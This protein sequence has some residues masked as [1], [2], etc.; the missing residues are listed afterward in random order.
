[1]ARPGP[2]P[3]LLARAR[4]L[5]GDSLPPSAVRE[6]LLAEG[7][8]VPLRTL[9]R[10]L[11]GRPKGAPRLPEGDGSRMTRWRQRRRQ[12][13]ALGWPPARAGR[14]RFPC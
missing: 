14:L 9:Q 10:W 2:D 4:E 7:K 1:M 11:A 3:A 6:L 8:D 5:A 13:G 12:Q